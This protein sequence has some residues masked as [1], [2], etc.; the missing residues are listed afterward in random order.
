M[1]SGGTVWI[2]LHVCIRLSHSSVDFNPL[3]GGLV[4]D[5]LTSTSLAG[6]QHDY[7]LLVSCWTVIKN[8]LYC[9]LAP[10][11]IEEELLLPL[12]SPL[13]GPLVLYRPVWLPVSLL[14]LGLVV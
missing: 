1:E 3:G 10:Q 13:S 12:V 2:G 6:G 11:V 7:C 9:P 4:T 5:C 14:C 8:P